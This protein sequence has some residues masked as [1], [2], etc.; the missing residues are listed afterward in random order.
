[1]ISP[2]SLIDSLFAFNLSYSGNLDSLCYLLIQLNS[3]RRNTWGVNL[4]SARM[5]Y[6][7][8]F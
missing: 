1:M 5:P 4:S 2:S 7:P 8:V 3:L 6:L